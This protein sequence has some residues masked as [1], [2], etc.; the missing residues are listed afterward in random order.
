MKIGDICQKEVLTCVGHE[1]VKH[2]ARRFSMISKK[3]VAWWH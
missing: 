1:S 3:Y 2:A